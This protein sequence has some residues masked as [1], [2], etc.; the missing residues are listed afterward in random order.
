M[1]P[2]ASVAPSSP[3]PVA[4]PPEAKPA[5]TPAPVDAKPAELELKLPDGLRLDDAG[6]QGFKTLAKEAGLDGAK[7]QKFVDLYAGFEK[8]KVDA[9][10]AQQKAWTEAIK[11][12]KDIGGTNLDK[13]LELSRRALTKF[14]GE[15]LVTFLDQ[16]GLGNHPALVRAFVAVGKAMAEDSVAGAT[17]NASDAVSGDPM[18][19]LAAKLFPDMKQK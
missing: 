1:P 2:P 12:D 7:A 3:A 5:A 14:G 16:S 11:A 10:A 6:L 18:A 15:G 17:P 13:S 9:Y 4:T 19:A 8:S